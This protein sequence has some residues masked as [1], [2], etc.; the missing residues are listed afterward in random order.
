MDD[1]HD[2]FFVARKSVGGLLFYLY[3]HTRIQNS[4][5]AS[6]SVLLMN[7]TLFFTDNSSP[8]QSVDPAEVHH[9]CTCTR[10]FL[11]CGDCVSES[12][13]FVFCYSTSPVV[14]GDYS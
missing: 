1:A 14:L 5:F 6:P 7:I 11:H 12:R 2:T 13:V 3:M 8:C 9:S 10:V 4:H